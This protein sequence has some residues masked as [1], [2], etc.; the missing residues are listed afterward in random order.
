M[1]ETK[2]I[3]VRLPLE[4]HKKLDEHKARTGEEKSDTIRR[5]LQLALGLGVETPPALVQQA[6]NGGPKAKPAEETVELGA[7]LSG[8]LGVPRVLARRR[9]SGKR[10]TVDGE[11]FT[12]ERL[13]KSRLDAVRVD[14]QPV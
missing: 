5:G 6:R 13:E 3:N 10:V 11:V 1:S 14:G 8:R 7:W 12:G 2:Q 4:L 9:I